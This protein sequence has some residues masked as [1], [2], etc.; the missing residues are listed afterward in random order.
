M[1]RSYK[2]A[3][4]R[5]RIEII[6]DVLEAISNEEKP[7]RVMYSANLS[8]G[9]LANII[10]KLESRG[11]VNVEFLENP[12]DRRQ[13]RALYLTPHGKMTLLDLKKTT[14]GWSDIVS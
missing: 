8:W 6:R 3:P 7:T 9:L 14:E 10:P 11:L 2:K 13:N 12:R 5:G 1:S 4:R